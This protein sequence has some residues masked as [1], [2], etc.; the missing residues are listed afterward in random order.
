MVNFR[1]FTISDDLFSGFTR[2]VDLDIV[3]NIEQ[4]IKI[5]VGDLKT[6]F[7]N[8]NFDILRETVEKRNFHIHDYSFEDMLLSEPNTTFYICSHC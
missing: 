6:V 1:K 8:N 3:E 2:P 4:I 7:N 5:V